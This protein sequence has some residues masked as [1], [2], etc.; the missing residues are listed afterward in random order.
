MSNSARMLAAIA[1]TLVL[2]TGCAEQGVRYG[3]AAPQVAS[4]TQSANSSQAGVAPSEQASG[5]LAGVTVIPLGKNNGVEARLPI[6]GYYAAPGMEIRFDASSSIGAVDEY[7]WDYDGDG[8]Y[9]A[10]TAA[11]IVKHTYED[12]FE[13]EMILRVS[14]M[15]GSSHVLK[16]PV[17]ISTKPYHQQLAPPNNVQVEILSTSNGI[18]EIKVIWESDDPA[19]ESWAVAINGMPIGRIEKAARSITVTDIE[20]KEDVL[21]EVFGLTGEMAVGLRAGTTLP[22]TK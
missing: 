18:S 9:D 21:V 10:T 19:A 16:T 3:Q 17:H 2:T 13:G 22:A 7:E 1:M 20:R 15:V 4:P 11:A 12:E 14:N 5:A 6:N 8:T